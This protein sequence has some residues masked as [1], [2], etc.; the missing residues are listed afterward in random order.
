MLSPAEKKSEPFGNIK[1][2]QRINAVFSPDGRWVAYQSTEPGNGELFVQPFPSAG[3]TKYQIHKSG[4]SINHHPL[5]SPDGKE[6]FYIPGP[7]RFLAVPI[8][9]Q[10]GFMF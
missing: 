3:T 1:S 9:T 4:V 10:S 8:S 2:T 5:W 6:L 7:N